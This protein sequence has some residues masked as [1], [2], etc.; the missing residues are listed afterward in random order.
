[1][2][3][4]GTTITHGPY[5]YV[6]ERE[7]SAGGFGTVFLARRTS[8]LP[9][10][11][12]AIKVPAPH[13]ATHP[14][15]SA[16]FEREARILS[17]I[18]HRNVAHIIAFWK[19]PDGDMAYAQEYV[20]DARD[21]KSAIQSNPDAAAS[22]LLQT[23]Y[24]A[25]AFHGSGAK[26][27]VHRDLSPN[28]ILVDSSGAV[29]IID[30]G[31]AKE[32]PRVTAVLTQANEWFGTPGCMS[33]EQF[34]DA[35]DVD[36]RADLFA[37]GR[38]FCAAIQ[39]RFPQH[40][41]LSILSD[42]WKTVCSTLA[43]HAPEDRYQ[44]ANDALS[45]CYAEFATMPSRINIGHFAMHAEENR[46]PVP[47]WPLFAY[48]FLTSRPMDINAVQDASLVGPETFSDPGFDA[49]KFFDLLERSSAIEA[50]ATGTASFDDCDPISELYTRMYASLDSG[51]RKR[52]FERVCTIA[53]RWHRYKA[54]DDIRKQYQ[55]ESDPVTRR[56]LVTI[57]D[58]L[59]PS[60]IV[61]GRGVLPRP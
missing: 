19:F 29:K 60:R 50:F 33:P 8:P 41:D 21:L 45:A 14:I 3:E 51:R 46:H 38:S 53:V 2:I 31:L 40:A 23:L 36:A 10:I 61:Q 59:D 57:L 9:V 58:R 32:D 4:R 18:R 39:N 17:N 56:E 5:Q 1:M 44:S 15:W 34:T 25:R 48:A 20:Q 54:M 24:G 28:N 42:P 35:A 55:I 30:F 49:T 26:G 16:K 12:V 43:M 27:A 22:Y 37:I 13:I 7:L 6:V 52:C 11:N 47:G